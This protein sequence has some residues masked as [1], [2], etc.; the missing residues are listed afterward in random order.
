MRRGEVFGGDGPSLR[1]PLRGLLA[2]G[3]AHLGVGS[4]QPPDEPIELGRKTWIDVAGVVEPA[5]HLLGVHPQYVLPTPWGLTGRKFVQ[6]DAQGVKVGA[7]VQGRPAVEL[8]RGG[9]HHRTCK[10]PSPGEPSGLI[11]RTCDAQVHQP[12]LAI[13]TADHVLGLH[14]TVHNALGMTGPQRQRD[15]APNVP[16]IGLGK[17][18]TLEPFV[19]HLPLNQLHGQPRLNL[20]SQRDHTTV[21]GTNNAGVYHPLAQLH[22]AHEALDQHVP[23]RE[24]TMQQLDR[25][26][27]AIVQRGSPHLAHSTR[28]QPV[29]EGVGGNAVARPQT[30]MLT[31]RRVHTDP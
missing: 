5:L 15:V 30:R 11:A 17:R 6:G 19:Q 28:T 26:L 29:D 3:R 23:K 18:P 14:V 13:G 16:H 22:L 27:L 12:N 31:F 7:L 24:R 25:H 9:I 1:H 2:V 10:L 21:E 20:G 8:L 4:G